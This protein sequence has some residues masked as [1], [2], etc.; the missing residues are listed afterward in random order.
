M[1]QF[2]SRLA[3]IWCVLVLF[4]QV[5]W[6]GA[7]AAAVPAPRGDALEMLVVFDPTISPAGQTGH[8]WG[9]VPS[10]QPDVASEGA[11]RARVPPLPDLIHFPPVQGTVNTKP[12]TARVVAA[13][14]QQVVAAAAY[15]GQ[16]WL[17]SGTA[18]DDGRSGP[19]RMIT[20]LRAS[21]P[22][23]EGAWSY[24]P[25]GRLEVAGQL[26]GDGRLVSVAGSSVGLLAMM[27]HAGAKRVEG[28]EA[29]ERFSLRVLD[30][31]GWTTIALPAGAE[32]GAEAEPMLAVPAAEG[33]MLLQRG[34]GQ[35]AGEISVWAGAIERKVVTPEPRK[36]ERK[37][38]GGDATRVREEP[39]RPRAELV[40]SWGPAR[41]Y[42]LPA[43]FV[44]EQALKDGIW[45]V[46]PG[47]RNISE[48]ARPIAILNLGGYLVAGR[49]VLD[50]KGQT[51]LVELFRLAEGPSV[52]L[53]AVKDRDVLA[54]V[55]LGAI[56]GSGTVRGV[57]LEVPP[58]ATPQERLRGQPP[59]EG[60]R[61]IELSK[62]RIM[63]VS[64]ATGI[65][66]EPRAASSGGLL[67]RRDFQT[68]WLLF[69][70]IGAILLLMV[71]RAGSGPAGAGSGDVAVFP[72]GWAVAARTPR[73]IAGVIDVM[74]ALAIT[75]L[76]FGMGPITVLKNVVDSSG[77]YGLG[78]LMVLIATGWAL[79][80]VAEWLSGR[81]LGKGLC[82][83]MVIG[84]HRQ[85]RAVSG[86]DES[87]EVKPTAGLEAGK[88]GLIKAILRNAVK[89]FL[90]PL[91]TL[92]LVD[93]LGRHPG[94]TL[95]KTFVIQE[96]SQEPQPPESEDGDR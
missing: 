84:N 58:P 40:A 60:R 86:D 20:T 22:V 26:P 12:G 7:M 81:T 19:R 61:A 55:A 92:F 27:D 49:P 79:G 29:S 6:A 89:W 46:T 94:D 83:I 51:R 73:V 31:L 53:D 42:Q 11:M 76:V 68:I 13:I 8:G 34:S 77:A 88:P 4:A 80:T 45:L 16:L 50:E 47:M 28:I 48:I 90:S 33:L 56:A 39:Q 59:I 15:G 44:N 3:A 96:V 25:L 62:L 64:L 21:G 66:S 43:E 75:G 82:G 32:L 54:S 18:A 85:Q 70:V 17:I 23:A 14:D 38:R 5:A 87:G 71:I 35:R 37:D 72:E 2:A 93:P 65:M 9:L 24:R 67:T 69:L 78:P 52:R 30:P 95:A 10:V 63:D 41:R 1:R 74:V 36:I 91:A 57:G